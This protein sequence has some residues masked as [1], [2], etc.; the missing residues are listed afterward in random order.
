VVPGEGV[1]DSSIIAMLPS[2]PPD[3]MSFIEVLRRCEAMVF[4]ELWWIRMGCCQLRADVVASSESLVPSECKGQ[5]VVCPSVPAVKML[6]EER[7]TDC[8]KHDVK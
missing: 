1:V 8:V 4:D 5:M 6:S 2:S 7:N 3:T